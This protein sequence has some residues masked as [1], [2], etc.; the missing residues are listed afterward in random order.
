MNTDE[1]RALKIL[2]EKY[3]DYELLLA[4]L[5]DWLR[6]YNWKEFPARK[7]EKPKMIAD[8]FEK[9]EYFK[10]DEKLASA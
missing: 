5:I 9:S 4:D 1:R 10:K 6:K 3:P 8:E 2:H 7:F